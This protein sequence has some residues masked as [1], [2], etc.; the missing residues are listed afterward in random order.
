MKSLISNYTFSAAAKTVTFTDFAS[1]DLNQVLVITN[2]T[3][4]VIIY[5][6]AALGG[7][8]AANVLTLDYDTTSMSDTDEL[9]IFIDVP[10]STSYG[11]GT[12]DAHTQRVVLAN[13]QSTLTVKL[14]TRSNAST[15]AYASSLVVK[16]SAGT[17]FSITGYNSSTASVFV[18]IHDATS[19]PANGAV[20]KVIFKVPGDSSFS[21]EFYGGRSFSTGIVICNSSTGPTKTIG[22]ADCWFDAQYI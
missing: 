10:D 20:P 1:I 17:L 3:D 7:S 2:I 19:L 22:A 6:F 15:A 8:V 5:N 16:S 13:D 18:Q 12:S 11:A 9:Q 14:T 21:L 4:N